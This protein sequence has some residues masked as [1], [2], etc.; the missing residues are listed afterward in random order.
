MTTRQII[1][2]CLLLAPIVTA[3]VSY[4]FYMLFWWI[5]CKRHGGDWKYYGER[6]LV[7]L[8]VTMMVVGVALVA[9]G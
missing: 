9:A 8:A 4:V 1:G 3:Y 6:L 5:E 7:S 2:L